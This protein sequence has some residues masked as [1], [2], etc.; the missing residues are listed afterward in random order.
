MYSF[1]VLYS[2]DCHLILVP[3]QRYWKIIKVM[4]IML[5]Q[6][7]NKRNIPNIYKGIVFICIMICMLILI[8][9]FLYKFKRRQK[10]TFNL[11][12]LLFSLFFT[13]G[14][15]LFTFIYSLCFYK[16]TLFPICLFIFLSI[17]DRSVINC[18]RKS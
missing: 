18:R 3:S 2:K 5:Q 11:T 10:K 15:N 12:L 9:F 13:V 7:D 1:N 17:E 14:L 4:I 6:N 8:M 16:L